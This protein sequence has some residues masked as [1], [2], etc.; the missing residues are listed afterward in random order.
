MNIKE[1]HYTICPVGNASY[2]AANKGWLKEGL[3]R[4]GVTPVLLQSLSS[5]WWK[6]HFDY[7]NDLL[8]REGGNIPPI[9]AKSNGAELVL[10]GWTVLRQKQY[11]LTLADAPIDCIEQLRGRRLC[12]PTH[13][14]S[15]IDF[16]K[17]S[18]Q[19]G[20][21]T[22]LAARGVSLSAVDFVE[23]PDRG[24]YYH[25]D[26]ERKRCFGWKEIA[27][28]DTGEVDAIFIKN[29]LVHQVL[30]TGRYK[31]LFALNA[32]PRLLAPVNN[33]YPNILT[34][35]RRVAEEAPEVVIEFIK[36]H[37]R[38]A[39][40]AKTHRSETL[41]LFGKQMFGTPGDVAE[42]HKFDFHRHLAT[43]FSQE[44]LFALEAQKR[45]LFD[46]GYLKR[47]FALEKW[48]DDRF[49]KAALAETES[50]Q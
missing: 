29:T 47:D 5:K 48:A 9:W 17:A 38:A 18:A 45:F 13:P 25:D 11:I 12:I 37:L 31:V 33:E 22:A 36:Q 15:L 6:T 42:S 8:F 43:G 4:H 39:E 14:D 41:E 23:V 26:E 2:I 44:G 30:A 28:L 49:Y 20:F 50:E 10:I 46:H 7:K 3:A 16:H 40:W 34:V 32:D 19:H 35:S 27:A 24:D 21:E 1:I